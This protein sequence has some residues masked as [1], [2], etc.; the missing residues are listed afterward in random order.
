[1]EDSQWLSKE[2]KQRME[3]L[4]KELA[5]LKAEH[6]DFAKNKNGLSP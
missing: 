1:M 2:D 4:K 5:A 3:A 6:K